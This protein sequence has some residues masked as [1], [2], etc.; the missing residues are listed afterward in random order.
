MGTKIEHLDTG[1]N[2]VTLKRDNYLLPRDRVWYES[3]N[4]G[5]KDIIIIE[6]SSDESEATVAV[7]P[8]VNTIVDP[9]RPEILIIEKLHL[10]KHLMDIKKGDEHPILIQSE[11][12]GPTKVYNITQE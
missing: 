12:Y 6:C 10:V 4:R 9:K 8:G 1:S 5:W 2:P 7:T 11:P 3:W